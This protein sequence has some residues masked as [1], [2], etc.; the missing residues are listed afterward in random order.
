ML[1]WQDRIKALQAAGMTQAEIGEE[2]GLATASVS[3]LARG[4][5]RSP[6]GEAALKLDTLYRT[7]GVRSSRRNA[8]A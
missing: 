3:D 1:T 2:V 6:R 4:V 8:A 7:K 5:T